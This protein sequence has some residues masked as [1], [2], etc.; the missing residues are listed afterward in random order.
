MTAHSKMTYMACGHAANATDGKGQ[1]ACVICVGLNRGAETPVEP[2]D[3]SHRQ[4]RCYCGLIRPSDS[5]HLAFFEYRGPGS[6]TATDHCKCGY[7]LVAHDIG[8]CRKR[9]A[10]N[11]L[12][13]VELGKCKGF[14]ARG[15]HEYDSFYCGCRGWD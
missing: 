11:Q 3:L 5:E 9:V 6:P 14:E 1:P 15:P 13:I 7:H 12:T 4:A 8:E 10:S 2:P